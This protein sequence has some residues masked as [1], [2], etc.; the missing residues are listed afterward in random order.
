MGTSRKATCWGGGAMWGSLQTLPGDSL[1]V[2][3]EQSG[4]GM[5]LQRLLLS[6]SWPQN[7]AEG[8]CLIPPSHNFFQKRCPEKLEA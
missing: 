3:V 4:Y 6:S 7:Q 1:G 5:G 2:R 8:V